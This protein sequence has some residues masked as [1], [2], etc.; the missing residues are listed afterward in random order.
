MTLLNAA[1]YNEAR[2]KAKTRILI[3][4]PVILLLAAVLALAGAFTGHGY[5]FM[6]LPV[7]HHVSTFLSA[8]QAGEYE[9]A[10]GIWWN[11]ANWQQHPEKYP[12]YPFKN[13]LRDFKNDTDW[14]SP[15]KTYH[16]DLSKRDDS[17]TVVAATINNSRKKLFLKYQKKDGT[18]S[19]TPMIIEY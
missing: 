5:F 17:G 6:N 13:F 9:K 4:I 10:Y 3:S 2:E 12:D 11:D 8:C 7:E 14:H 19:F 1:E 15:V 18:L 16:V